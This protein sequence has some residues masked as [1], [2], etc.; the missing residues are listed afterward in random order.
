M[1]M[2]SVTPLYAAL[3][4]L[5]FLP[6]TMRAGLYRVSCGWILYNTF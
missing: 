2:L 1:E 5:L 3:L 6:F 4:G